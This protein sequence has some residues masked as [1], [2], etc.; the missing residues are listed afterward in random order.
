VLA[1]FITFRTYGSWLHGDRQGSVDRYRNV[2]G[3]DRIAGSRELRQRSMGHLKSDAVVL[4]E[5]QREICT[6]AIQALC[7]QRSWILHALNVR[8]NHVHA[9][10]TSPVFA[11]RTMSDFKAFA[12]K[13]LR[14]KQQLPN[15]LRVW[16]YHGSTHLLFKPQRVED[17]CRYV[18]E[19]QG[20]R[21]GVVGS[22]P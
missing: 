6:S 21:Q 17:A 22:E 12:T 19:G 20:A 18:I 15:A 1:Y 2:P 11:D 7:T 10:V 3:T 8:S 14:E 9:V 13:A 5:L 16:A 4:T